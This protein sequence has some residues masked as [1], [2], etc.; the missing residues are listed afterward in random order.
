MQDPKLLA[1]GLSDL[2]K[3]IGVNIV[4]NHAATKEYKEN[5]QA[6]SNPRGGRRSADADGDAEGDNYP[7]STVA[8]P[9]T[10]QPKDLYRAME[11]P[12][13]EL[14]QLRMQHLFSEMA[15]ELQLERGRKGEY[16]ASNS[17]SRTFSAMDREREALGRQESA[18]NGGGYSDDDFFAQL[19]LIM[20]ETDP[21]IPV[22]DD[23][24]LKDGKSSLAIKPIVMGDAV[25]PPIDCPLSVLHVRRTNIKFDSILF[26]D[27]LIFHSF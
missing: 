21:S 17:F 24:H 16:F 6:S 25:P 1:E 9:N 14:A 22:P 26:R 13:G 3:S 4:P 23:P 5:T 20:W 8:M 15:T 11:H 2:L 7:W 27:G 18:C 10:D 19:P 12:G